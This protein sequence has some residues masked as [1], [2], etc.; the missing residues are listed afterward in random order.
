LET[1]QL[2]SASA[3][4]NHDDASGISENESP[5]PI[6]SGDAQDSSRNSLASAVTHPDSAEDENETQT[7]R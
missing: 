4:A 1:G 6:L 3:F 2:D 5:A 7:T